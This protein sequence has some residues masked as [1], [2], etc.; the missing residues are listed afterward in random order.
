MFRNSIH[1]HLHGHFLIMIGHR[2]NICRSFFTLSFFY[3]NPPSS[4]TALSAVVRGKEAVQRATE[5]ILLQIALNGAWSGYLP[6]R[7]QLSAGWKGKYIISYTKYWKMKKQNRNRDSAYCE[8]IWFINF[9]QRKKIYD[10]FNIC[11]NLG[12]SQECS[13][14]VIHKNHIV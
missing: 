6:G 12:S 14:C 3:S 1:M 10:L 8:N 7:R 11:K 13:G 4:W 9:Q 5:I 2:A